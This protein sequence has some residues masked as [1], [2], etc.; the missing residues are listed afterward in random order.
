M[1]APDLRLVLPAKAENVGVVRHALAGLAEALGMEPGRIGDLKTVVTEACMNAVVHAYADEGGGPM[2][3]DAT[4][5]EGA[6]VVVVRDHGSG[7]RPRADIERQSLRMG[8]PLI[9]ALSNG[10]EISG[11]PDRGTV[12][13]M[14]LLLS[15]NG[16]KPEAASAA[17]VAPGAAMSMPAGVLVGPVL[18]RVIS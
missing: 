18:S 16:S 14:R 3:V 12:V 6:L 5:D 15:A 7:I 10:F 2:E 9:A 4:R 8:L 17:D 11:G 13:T 1:I